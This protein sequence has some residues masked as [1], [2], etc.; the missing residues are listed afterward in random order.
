METVLTIIAIVAIL[1]VL[2]LMFIYKRKTLMQWLL[3]AVVIAEEELG[4]GIGAEKL[5]LVHD[6]LVA[7]FPIVGRI[8]PFAIFSH[9]VDK[10]LDLMKDEL[11]KA[12]QRYEENLGQN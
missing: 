1:A 8:L 10:A 3:K 9:L 2:V 5:Q 12:L 7:R 4:G 11:E 6:R